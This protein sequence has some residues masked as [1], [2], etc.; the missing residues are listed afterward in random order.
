MD[1]A[2]LSKA[3]LLNTNTGER[4]PVMY[5]PEQFSLDQGNSF[6]E[7]GIPGLAAPPVQY[8]RG[9]LRTLSVELFFDTYETQQD[10]RDFTGKI[11]GLLDQD[12]KTFA[13]PVLIFTM[14]QFHFQCVLVDAPQKFTMFLRDGTPVRSTLSC[15]FEEYTPI[16]VNIQSGLFIG[17]PT[18]QNIVSGVAKTLNVGI[19]N[20]SPM[21]YVVGVGDTLQK[22][23]A[24]LLG[25]ASRWREL[26]SANKIDDPF[27]LAPGKKLV[28]PGRKNA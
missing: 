26:A 17:P 18:I 1:L 24:D 14:G 7:V 11:V 3:F 16:Q 19:A 9:K 25:D 6:A 13:P 12:P 15:K 4:I 10:V 8:V 5:N 28:V 27:H 22:I 23:A 21:N 2:Q 20:S